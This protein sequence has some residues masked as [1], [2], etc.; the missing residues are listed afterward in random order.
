M[1]RAI[2]ETRVIPR[3][4][5]P[6]SAGIR[7]TPEEFDSCPPESWQDGY[8]Y[9]LIG[10]FLVVTPIAGPAEADPNDELG[11]LL[12]RYAEDEPGRSLLDATLPERHVAGNSNRRRADRVIWVGLGRTPNEQADVPAI[13]IEFV[14]GRRRDAVRDYQEKRDEYLAA[15]VLEYWVIDRFR[16][17]LTVYRP[18][19]QGPVATV[20][21]ETQTYESPL[22]PGFVLPL[23]RLLARADDWSRRRRKPQ[24]PG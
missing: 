13:V 1:S 8:R 11:Y 12:R 9:E 23:G 14:S 3:R 20:I 5:G 2:A 4:L 17:T 7:L 22:L 15:G 21:G 19:P 10:G 24:P 16:R 18:G 6:A